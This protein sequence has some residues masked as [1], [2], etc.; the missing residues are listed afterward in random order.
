MH[1]R[2]GPDC[3]SA[4]WTAG[5]YD[6]IRGSHE[7]DI[8]GGIDQRSSLLFKSVSVRETTKKRRETEV[9]DPCKTE[10]MQFSAKNVRK[11]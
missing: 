1:L 10:F 2:G 4:H 5:N 9:A 3:L 8:P 11:S 7:G 6:L